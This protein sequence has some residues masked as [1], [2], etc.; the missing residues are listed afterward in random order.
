MVNETLRQ[1]LLAMRA[2]DLQVR[3]ELL[4]ANLLGGPYVPRMQ[5]VHVKNAARLR[6]LIAEFGWPSEELAGPDGAESAWLVAQHAVGEPEF[7]KQAL[8]LTR[9]ASEKGILPAWHSAFLEDRIALH[10]NRPQRFGT[11]SIDDVRD[12]IRR[13]W[14]LADPE[15][16]NKLRAS[17]GLK[18][19]WPIA[20]PGPDLPKE[21]REENEVI[22]KWWLDWL[23]SCG[24]GTSQK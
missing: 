11:Q 2:E 14:T 7:M 22:R 3:E 12:G 1:E 15:R 16:V 13:P 23:A 20:P 4:A 24:W 17:V 19:L 21:Q 18:P 9:A 10:E 6:E 8:H 5:E